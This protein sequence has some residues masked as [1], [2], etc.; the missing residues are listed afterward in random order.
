MLKR[1]NEF[2]DNENIN[3]RYNCN[4]SK[5]YSNKRGPNLHIQNILFSLYDDMSD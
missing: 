3:P 1:N 5:L 4:R 2:N